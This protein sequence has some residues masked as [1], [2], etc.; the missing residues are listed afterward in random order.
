MN[1][2]HGMKTTL[3]L[4]TLV[5]LCGCS[6]SI[7]ERTLYEAACRRVRESEAVPRGVKPAPRRKAVINVGK[8]S[9]CVVLPYEYRIGDKETASGSHTVWFKRVG[10][11]WEVDRSFPT[12]PT[13]PH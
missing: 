13:Q 9:A 8:N 2:G 10:M 12:A 3:T 5:L 1:S 7:T 11:R 6:L 4:I